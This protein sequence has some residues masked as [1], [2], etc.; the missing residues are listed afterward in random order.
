MYGHWVAAAHPHDDARPG[1]ELARPVLDNPFK[2]RGVKLIGLHLQA[3]ASRRRR[4][5]DPVTERLSA[6]ATR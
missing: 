6:D 3:V 1:G 5:H 4:D 2:L